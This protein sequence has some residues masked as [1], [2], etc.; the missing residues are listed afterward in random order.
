VV[1]PLGFG[2]FELEVEYRGI[3]RRFAVE[4]NDTPLQDMWW[5][6]P[7]EN[8]WGMSVVQHGER[9]FAAIYAYDA[10]GK[11]TWYVMPGGTW[12][13]ARTAFTGAIFSPRGSPY[14]A[15]DPSRL[16]VG[17]AVGQVTIALGADQ[18]T[19]DFTIGG[20]SGRKAMTRQ[21][22]GPVESTAA[23]L[24]AADMWWGGAS[25][26]GWGLALLQQ[27]RTLF[28]VWFTYDAAGSPTWFVL[29]SGFWADAHTWQGRIYRATS[30][31]WLGAPYDASR[32]SSADVGSFTLSFEGGDATLS[33][34]IDG[35]AGMI[36]LMR[37][38]F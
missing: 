35:K 1:T 29:P 30:S 8:G 7:A 18:G 5:A 28:G 32:L 23:P 22:F 9:L 13:A 24:S 17:E 6:G 20:V 19:L 34:T 16:V 31:P 3:K 10:A 37:Q 27:H 21:L 15:Y 33:Y 38:A 11:P 2:D 14:S 26:N 36:P 25:Q 4:G 12:N